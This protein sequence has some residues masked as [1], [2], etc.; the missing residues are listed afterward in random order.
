MDRCQPLDFR[1]EIRGLITPKET[2]LTPPFWVG[3]WGVD[4]SKMAACRK[5]RKLSLRPDS[6]RGWWEWHFFK[7][8]VLCL[9]RCLRSSL[10]RAR[11]ASAISDCLLTYAVGMFTYSIYL[12]LFTP[13]ETSRPVARLP[14]KKL[15]WS[16]QQWGICSCWF[17]GCDVWLACKFSWEGFEKLL[18]VALPLF[19]HSLSRASSQT[20]KRIAEILCFLRWRIL[21]RHGWAL[22]GTWQHICLTTSDWRSS[23]EGRSKRS[24]FTGWSSETFMMAVKRALAHT[25]RLVQLRAFWWKSLIKGIVLES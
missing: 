9:G 17:F 18:I 3:N 11:H 7:E 1:S 20:L 22:L 21:R 23:S 5:I 10:R 19:G 12:L 16:R 24:S 6:R 15:A 2:S 25:E 13:V 4:S 8:K 14:R